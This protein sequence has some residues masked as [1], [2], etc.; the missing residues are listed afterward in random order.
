VASHQR[1]RISAAMIELVA[2]RGYGAVTIRELAQRAGVSTHSFYERFQSKDE[3]FLYTYELIVRRSMKTVGAA[4]KSCEDWCERQRLAFR[5]WAQE[6]ADEPQAA[7]FALVEAFAGGPEALERTRHSEALFAELIERSFASAPEAVPVPPLV[8]QG[9]VAGVHRV[10]RATLLAGR[11]RAFPDLT[12]ELLG[13]MLCFQSEASAELARLDHAPVPSWGAPAGTPS[14]RPSSSNG[15]GADDGSDG[16]ESDYERDD[17]ARIIDAVARLVTTEGYRQLKVTRIRLVAGV[18][19]KRFDA[20]FADIHECFSATLEHL[21]GS[22]LAHAAAA[23][24]AGRTWPGGL[25]RA[26]Y[27]LCVYI[28]TDPVFAQLG[29]V[30]VFEPGLD[31]MRRRNNVLANVA[32]ALRA[33]APAEQRPSELAAEASVGAVWGIAR[34]CIAADH[35]R[36]LQRIAPTLAFLALAPAI[37]GAQAVREIVAEHARMF[38]NAV[39]DGGRRPP[40]AGASGRGT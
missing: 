37:G 35:A 7:W 32:E 38:P 24:R 8:I 36:E 3:C 1:A 4:Q 2:E 16:G 11:E 25:Y 18:S 15:D 39:A 27:A 22:A 13:W 9:I 14:S 20:Q 10:A 29:F 30:R 40:S 17:R 6:I 21:T 34:R 26:I 23:G 5:A 19:R 12:D 31:G 33:S 28:A